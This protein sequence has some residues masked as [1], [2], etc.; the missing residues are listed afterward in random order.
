M[1]GDDLAKLAPFSYE[2][3]DAIQDSILNLD[4]KLKGLLSEIEAKRKLLTLSPDTGAM[5][6]QRHLMHFSMEIKKALASM[7]AVVDAVN[8]DTDTNCQQTLK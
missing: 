6:Q 7:G 5:E 4:Q 1:I 3:D 2:A 8:R